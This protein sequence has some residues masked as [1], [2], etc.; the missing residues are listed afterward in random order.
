MLVKLISRLSELRPENPALLAAP[1]NGP[2]GPSSVEATKR[3]G[4]L[5]RGTG[6]TIAS[7]VESVREVPFLANPQL[8]TAMPHLPVSMRKW[9]MRQC[10]S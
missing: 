7:R 6:G 8:P 10:R 4:R 3:G 9:L 1:D 5:Q 2:I